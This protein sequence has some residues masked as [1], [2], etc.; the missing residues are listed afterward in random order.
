M[1]ISRRG[2]RALLAVA[3]GA[4]GAIGPAATA[5]AAPAAPKPRLVL[6]A[7]P[8]VAV[9]SGGR[10]VVHEELWNLGNAPENAPVVLSVSLAPGVFVT[11]L[12]PQCAPQPLGHTAICH[13]PAGLKPGHA[14]KVTIPIA[15][16][17]HLRPAILTGIA[18]GG[19]TTKPA[20]GSPAKF[21][22]VVLP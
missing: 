13:F 5:T 2:G 10:S 19:T 4:C 3:L 16:A 17:T 12:P 11:N 20:W 9:P 18:Q 14:D 8:L 1:V 6:A 15:A 7:P 21:L 22:L